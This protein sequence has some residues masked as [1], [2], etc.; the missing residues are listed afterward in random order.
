MSIPEE[1]VKLAERFIKPKLDGR[2]DQTRQLLY[3]RQEEA[4]RAGRLQSQYYATD[5][6]ALC[7]AEIE[8]R[9]DVIWNAYKQVITESRVPWTDAV[10]DRI[11]KRISVMLD[12]DIPYVEEAAR[13]VI[14][15]HGHGFALFLHDARPQIVSR[16]GAEME[17]FALSYRPVDV[18]V[19]EQLL[20]PR[21]TGPL[22][23][24]I[25]ADRA[26]EQSPP[27]L[28]A[29]AREAVNGVEAL[30]K[31]VAVLPTGTLGDCIKALRSTNKLDG[32]RG[33]DLESLWAFANSRFRHGAVVPHRLSE[34]DYDYVIHSCVAAMKLLLSLDIP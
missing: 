31:I 22:D 33:K 27:D 20:A 19:R 6:Q 12:A 13:Q 10:R 2:N 30:A 29:S 1:L 16:I 3:R 32:P 24:W 25:R 26:A 23:H 28:V 17:L 18:S 21:Y 4:S 8:S 15:G 34:E 11:D 5:Q 14:V 7:I 9:A